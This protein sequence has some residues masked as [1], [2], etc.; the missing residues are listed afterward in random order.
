MEQTHTQEL[1]Q[2]CQL[3][4]GQVVFKA[5]KAEVLSDID[6]D[7]VKSQGYSFQIEMNF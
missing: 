5:W 3:W 7:S 1:S 6:L 2:V 4:M